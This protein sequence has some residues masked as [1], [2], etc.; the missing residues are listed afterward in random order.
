MRHYLDVYPS[1]IKEPHFQIELGCIINGVNLTDFS[2]DTG[3]IVDRSPVV[4]QAD[5]VTG[6]H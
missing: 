1:S 5:V 6:S 3:R 4:R 2:E